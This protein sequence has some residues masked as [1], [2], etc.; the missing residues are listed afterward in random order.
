[1]PVRFIAGLIPAIMYG[2]WLLNRCALNFRSIG[3]V[4]YVFFMSCVTS[5]GM[6]FSSS[7]DRFLNTRCFA[8]KCIVGVKRADR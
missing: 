5:V 8:P 7:R 1:M 3:N 2:L 4:I 6:P